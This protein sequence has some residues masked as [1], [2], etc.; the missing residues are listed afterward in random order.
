MGTQVV[1]EPCW[2]RAN[3]LKALEGNELCFGS[4]GK[5]T[6]FCSSRR[7]DSRL[8]SLSGQQEQMI[9]VSFERPVCYHAEMTNLCSG[10]GFFILS[11]PSWTAILLTDGIWLQGRK[12]Q[13]CGSWMS[14]SKS[15]CL[16]ISIWGEV[17]S[18]LKML[19]AHPVCGRRA[20]TSNWFLEKM[21]IVV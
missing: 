19:L 5:I 17:W 6:W 14:L 20:G 3:H 21:Y 11:L 13:L 18:R 15:K 16:I 9:L 2:P 4:W 8:R 7:A 1:L 10:W 12:M